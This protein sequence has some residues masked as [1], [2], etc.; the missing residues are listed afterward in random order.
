MLSNKEAILP[1]RGLFILRPELLS[2]IYDFV[3]FP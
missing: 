1:S 3:E 2:K